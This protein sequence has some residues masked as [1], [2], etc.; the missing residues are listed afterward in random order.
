MAPHPA[1]KV[2]QEEVEA[3]VICSPK[4]PQIPADS[5]SQW[6]ALPSF[7]LKLRHQGSKCRLWE[8]LGTL[9]E[10][11]NVGPTLI[12]FPHTCICQTQP[13]SKAQQ[14]T[15]G[16]L[17]RSHQGIPGPGPSSKAIF[18]SLPSDSRM[19]NTLGSRDLRPWKPLQAT[20]SNH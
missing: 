11:I 14:K 20:A 5:L 9:P 1:R 10:Y 2:P 3:C 8:G 19:W 7:L 18:Y 15:W 4:S 13:P 12:P 16:S 6:Q 17:Q